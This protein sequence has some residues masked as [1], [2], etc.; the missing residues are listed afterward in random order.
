MSLK[1]KLKAV[2]VGVTASFAVVSTSSS[3]DVILHAFNWTYDEVASKASEIANLGYKK[4]LVS[5]AYK[6]T[7]SQWWA[8]YQPQ[9]YR[10]IDNPLGDTNDFKAMINALKARG[11]DVYADIVFNHM[12][13]E[14]AIRSDLNYPGSNVLSQY[15]SSS[16]YY[17]SITMFGNISNNLFGSGDFHAPGC[18]SNY[19]DPGEVQYYRLCGGNGDPG[20]PDLDPNNW[21]VQQQ[22]SYLQA[23]KSYG[24]KGFRVD[25]AK[26]MTNY[27]I[28]A[29]FDSNIK[30]GVHVFGEII[31]S[32][33]A[34]TNEY[35]AFLAPY[36]NNTGH[37]AYD[38]PLFE[39][40]R[41]A[42]SFGGSM[43]RLVDP[44]A[45]GQALPPSKAI[46]FSVT[47]DIPLNDGFRYQILD[48]TD[49]TLANA[50][51]LGRD[52][53]TPLMYSDHN[54]SGDNRWNNLYKRSDITNMIRFHNATQGRSM[55]VVAYNDCYILFQRE[56][57]G[58]VGINKCG[59]GQNVSVD[60]DAEGLYWYR[61]YTD[62]LSG[63]TQYITSKFHNFHI[64]ARSARMWLLQ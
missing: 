48:A 2:A 36:L 37:A 35:D 24:V 1:S 58:M 23:L 28:N 8:R 34:G 27:H 41:Q 14:S 18:I 13:N 59:S 42:F 64:P 3:A 22:K 57:V 5:P 39:Q 33:G 44:I 63:N 51:I 43:N 15:S 52:G 50:Y 49:E 55:E 21:V 53:G 4:V 31:T 9:D 38:F 61:N 11:V 30:N 10:V 46:T 20:L 40:I 25:A 60:A 12:A 47:H 29:V 19:S 54:E 17:N 62:T 6:S 7:G 16:S 56:H 45:Y 32:G 26:H